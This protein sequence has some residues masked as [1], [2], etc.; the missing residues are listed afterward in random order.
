MFKLVA[1]YLPSFDEKINSLLED[2]WRLHG[3]TFSHPPYICQALTKGKKHTI[4]TRKIKSTLP[5]GQ[6]RVV[7]LGLLTGTVDLETYEK[8]VDNTNN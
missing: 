1:S 4:S 6:P 7:G 3:D 5:V 8:S 2:G